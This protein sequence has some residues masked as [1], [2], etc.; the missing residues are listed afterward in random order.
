[1]G[2]DK[3]AAASATSPATFL[4]RS[5]LPYTPGP[6]TA[7]EFA[8]YWEQG[9]LIKQGITTPQ[10]LRNVQDAIDAEVDGVA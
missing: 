8:L 6:L 1:M 3:V 10:L 5:K 7:E 9:F 2:L 4:G